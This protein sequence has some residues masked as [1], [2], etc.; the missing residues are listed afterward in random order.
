M[1]SGSGRGVIDGGAVLAD[2]WRSE[3]TMRRNGKYFDGGFA[4]AKIGVMPHLASSVSA[5]LAASM[6]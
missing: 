2:K 6:E 1:R 5:G 3:A 4:E